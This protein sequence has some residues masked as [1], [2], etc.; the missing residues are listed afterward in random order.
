MDIFVFHSPGLP[1]GVAASCAAIRQDLQVGR[2]ERPH[3]LPPGTAEDPPIPAGREPG[4]WPGILPAAGGAEAGAPGTAPSRA[5]TPARAGG[6]AGAD[7]EAAA[8]A[9]NN[10]AIQQDPAD[11]LRRAPSRG[12]PAP[13]GAV[14]QCRRRRSRTPP[15]PPPSAEPHRGGGRRLGGARQ[16]RGSRR[17]RPFPLQRPAGCSPTP[18]P[19]PSAARAGAVT[20]HNR[21]RLRRR[22]GGGGGASPSSPPATADVRSLHLASPAGGGGQE[23]PQQ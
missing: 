3:L 11:I 4:T 16:H 12:G 19:A 9:L 18:A 6:T 5:Q 15:T 1:A 10:I 8:P 17:V 14:P 7:A 2:G 13:D 21:R 23:Q 22:G 20:C